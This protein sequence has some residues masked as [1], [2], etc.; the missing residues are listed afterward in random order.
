VART[1]TLAMRSSRLFS[2]CRRIPGSFRTRNA[3][4][5][6]SYGKV[7]I[8]CQAITDTGPRKAALR[9]VWPDASV[10]WVER[11]ETHQIAGRKR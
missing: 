5:A 7:D 11:S 6:R 2:G 10:G 4:V 1:R 9:Q 8:D 3:F